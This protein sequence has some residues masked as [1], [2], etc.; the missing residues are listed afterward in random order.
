[1]DQA[2]YLFNQG[3]ILASGVISRAVLEERLKKLCDQNNC[4]PAK[5]RPTIIDYNT[6]LYKD[7]VYDK[8]IFKNVDSMAAIGNDVAHN[9][10]N[11]KKEDVERLLHDLNSFLQRF[12]VS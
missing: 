11:V 3:Y 4:Q 7:Q 8:I 5:Q 1:M 9:K 12:S 2:E 10:P 6:N